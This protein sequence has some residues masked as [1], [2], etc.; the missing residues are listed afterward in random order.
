MMDLRQ[1]RMCNECPRCGATDET[2]LHVLRYWSK[3]AQKKWKKGIC[4]L[5]QWMRWSSTQTNVQIAIGT[6]F[7]NFNKGNNFDTYAPSTSSSNL[8]LCLL[9]QSCIGW[10]GF[11]EGF[12]S[13]LWAEQQEQYFQSWDNWHSGCHWA[14]E[15]SKKLWKLVFSM[16]EHQNDTLCTTSKIDNLSSLQIVKKA[17]QQEPS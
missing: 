13:L 17:I 12:L 2:T 10:T 3:G 9:A 11:L 15:L 5:E 6:V 14:V 1:S 8:E 7:Q 4:Q 16:W